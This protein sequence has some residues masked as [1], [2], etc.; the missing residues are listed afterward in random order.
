MSANEPELPIRKIVV[1]LDA[2]SSSRALLEAAAELAAR[3]HTEL[4]GLFVEDAQLVD[5]AGSPFFRE[6]SRFS[7][8]AHQLSSAQLER[9]LRGQAS[10]M[11]RVLT[12]ITGR[13]QVPSTLRIVRGQV[14]N[15]LL[16]A[17]AETDLIILGRVG[18]SF[19]RQQSA[20]KRLGSTT[21]VFLTQAPCLTLVWQQETRLGLPMVVVYDN[22]AAAQRALSLA[23]RLVQ[24]REGR[25]TVILLDNTLEAIQQAEQQVRAWLQTRGLTAH[26]HKLTNT[27]VA[28]LA[29][30]V[31]Q[32]RARIMVL[33]GTNA[34]LQ[35]EA[36]LAL[37]DEL[38]TSVL[39]VQ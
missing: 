3:F 35:G 13:R 5:L 28:R 38:R 31:M 26:F 34:A 11:Q 7:A 37:L 18:Q 39:I 25:L 23:A 29:Q 10:Q 33:P 9:Q 22:S 1:A 14:V 21:R 32:E 15:E 17:A 4:V 8:S 2:S 19:V 12:E 36:L 24:E 16:R 20:P 6:I 27:N 30:I